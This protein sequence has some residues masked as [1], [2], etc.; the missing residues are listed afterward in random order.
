[1]QQVAVTVFNVDE[2]KAQLPGTGG[3]RDKALCKGGNLA[4]AQHCRIF[5]YSDPAV[6]NRVPERGS[7]P[8][9]AFTRGP[10]IAPGVGQLQAD[11]Q[12][13][14]VPVG[15]AVGSPTAG[16]HLAN[17]PD[18]V[19]G[20]PQLARVHPPFIGDGSRLAPDDRGPAVTESLVSPD[21][22]FVGQTLE[23]AIAAFHRLNCQ[24]IFYRTST[25]RQRC[26]QRGHVLLQVQFESQ[27]RGV[28]EQVVTGVVLEVTG[29]GWR[30]REGVVG[31]LVPGIR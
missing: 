19:L 5:C 10:G 17:R 21:R 26:K 14:I 9:A 23:R 31:E 16:E 29:H 2:I 6:E 27:R 1:M 28:G 15:L 24:A 11:Q 12:T 20:Q 7:R 18:G 13:V 25:D 3:G 4:V 30:S 22:Q 8:A